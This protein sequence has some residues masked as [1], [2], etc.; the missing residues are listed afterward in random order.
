LPR[1]T[2]NGSQPESFGLALVAQDV[3]VRFDL[4]LAR[5]RTMRRAIA[6][7]LRAVAHPLPPAEFWAIRDISF[8]L[9]P[10][11]ILGVVGRNGSGK[12]T[13]LATLAGVMPPDEGLVAAFGGVPSLLTLGAGFEQE[14]TGRENIYLNGTYLGYDREY[15]ESRYWDIVTFS[16]LGSFID[17]PLKKYSTGMRARLGFSI[18]A[19]TDPSTMLIDEVFGVG[20][21]AFSEKSRK[22]MMEIVQG[23]RSIVIVSHSMGF[24]REIAHRVMWIHEGKLVTIGEPDT[25]TRDYENAVEADEGAVRS[26]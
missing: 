13:L 1:S 9:A 4:G 19:F 2:D 24:L 18:A 14:L 15:I 11:E 22:K 8:S 5:H 20:D 21:V 16:E 3:G 23:P 10:G 6:T 17:V 7:T 25:V 12:S 26:I